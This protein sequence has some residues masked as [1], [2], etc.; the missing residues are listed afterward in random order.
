[1][2]AAREE[3]SIVRALVRVPHREHGAM[4]HAAA[5][6]TDVR[7]AHPPASCRVEAEVIAEAGAYSGRLP[8]TRPHR[9]PCLQRVCHPRIRWRGSCVLQHDCDVAIE[10]P[11][12]ER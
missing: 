2:I 9:A 6:R 5:R 11:A 1:M 7:S 10:V 12:S 8:A 3:N 4:T